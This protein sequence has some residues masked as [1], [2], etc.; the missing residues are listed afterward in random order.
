MYKKILLVFVFVVAALAGCYVLA[1]KRAPAELTEEAEVSLSAATATL[2]P[3][4]PT[5]TPEPPTATPMGTPSSTATPTFASPTKK[6]FLLTPALVLPPTST[7]TGTPE[8][9]VTP[10]DTPTLAPTVDPHSLLE[11]YELVFSVFLEEKLAKREGVQYH[12]CQGYWADG[13]LQPCGLVPPPGRYYFALEHRD[14]GRIEERIIQGNLVEILD[15]MNLPI[16]AQNERGY[17][18]LSVASDE[19]E[20]PTEPLKWP[21]EPLKGEKL[22]GGVVFSVQDRR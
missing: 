10:T 14:L 8:P 16:E 5:A 17:M 12:T 1:V 11:G 6:C 7:A 20:W 13:E 2:T 18:M 4:L 22:I 9:T 3:K 15:G 21:T 19:F